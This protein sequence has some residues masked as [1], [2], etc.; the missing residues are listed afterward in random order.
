MIFLIELA[1]RK[2]E[3]QA[4]GTVQP[5]ARRTDAAFRRK[6]ARAQQAQTRPQASR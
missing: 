2:A 5:L 4:L 3:R 6:I 1:T